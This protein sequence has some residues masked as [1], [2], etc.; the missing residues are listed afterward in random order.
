MIHYPNRDDLTKN[1]WKN[2][3]KIYV[4]AQGIEFHVN[5]DCEQDAIDYIIDYCADEDEGNMPG[6]VADYRELLDDGITENEI[7]DYICGG[8]KSLYLTTHNIHIEKL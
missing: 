5:A 1:F 2:N 6:L 3:Y 4:T 8:N 7:N